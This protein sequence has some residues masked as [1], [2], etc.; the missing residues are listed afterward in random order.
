[1]KKIDIRID[2]A[3]ILSY[4]VELKDNLPSITA[5]IGLF[6]AD[7]Q[8]S[9]FSLR[10]EEYYGNSIV[11]SLPPQIINPI[12]DIAKQL[13]TILIK[14]CNESFLQLTDGKDKK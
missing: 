10:T 2:K 6:S 9:T 11:F 3:K 12:K 8:I 4:E 5:T 1:M 14:K 7:K 13:E